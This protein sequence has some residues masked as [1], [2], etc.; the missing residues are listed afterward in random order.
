MSEVKRNHH[1]PRF[2][3][4]GWAE[5]EGKVALRRR[6]E[7]ASRLT[8]VQ[9]V[10]VRNRFYTPEAESQLG[11]TE[12]AAAPVIKSVFA[13]VKALDSRE[14]RCVL[15]QFMVE[16]MGRQPYMATFKGL[17]QRAFVAILESSGDEEEIFQILRDEHGPYVRREDAGEIWGAI[18]EM[19]QGL[20]RDY[21]DLTEDEINEGIHAV[22]VDPDASQ[23]LHSTVIEYEESAHLIEDRSSDLLSRRWL[24]CE[25]TGKEFI[26]SDQPVFKH[27]TW[28]DRNG[29]GSQD[30][31]CFVISPMILLK[32]GDESGH[33]RW[34]EKEVHEL[35]LYIAEHCD[36]QIIATPTNENYLS[37]LRL[38]KYR[39]WGF[40]RSPLPPRVPRRVAT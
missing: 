33:R 38:E 7:K 14:N 24:L 39:P 26:T 36:H 20:S 27:P 4:D 10:G 25:T 17:S 5:S 6:G 40:A 28:L 22:A 19:G 35:N 2:Y 15:A 37:Q 34:G 32:M 1:L 16:L 23:S 9:N 18:Q 31:L 29:I 30:T 8:S 3:I 11:R 13:D 21:P 12:T